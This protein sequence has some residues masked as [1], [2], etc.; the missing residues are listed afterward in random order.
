M[1]IRDSTRD[2]LHTPRTSCAPA[3]PAPR[4]RPPAQPNL[5]SCQGYPPTPE[6][7]GPQPH[8]PPPGR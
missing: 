8:R 7:P 4:P 3:W 2:G 1:C 6:R 5:L